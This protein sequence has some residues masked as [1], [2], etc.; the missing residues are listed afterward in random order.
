M[1]AQNQ[2]SYKKPENQGCWLNDVAYDKGPKKHPQEKDDRC[3]Q[4]EK[5]HTPGTIQFSSFPWR[6]GY[7]Q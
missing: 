6:H 5:D 4:E 3:D 2:N 1:D 7:A